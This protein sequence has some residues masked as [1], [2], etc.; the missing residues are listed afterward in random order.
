MK[1]LRTNWKMGMLL[2]DT[3]VCIDCE[4]TGL[5]TETD[6]IIE[7]AIVKFNLDGV[8]DSY[9][10]L[11]DPKRDIPEESTV[12]HHI[13]DDMVQG[14]PTIDQVL[15]KV[16]AIA[17][18]HTI[19]GHGIQFDI[20][21][22]VNAAK[23]NDIPCTLQNRPSLDTLRLARLYG[24]A[25][26][27]SL[28]MLR[29]HFNIPEQGAHRA[30]NDVMVNID[31]F[32][33]LVRD[34][35]T[36]DQVHKALSKP[37]RLKNMPLGKH[38]GRP[39]KEVPVEYLRWAANKDFDQDLLFSIRSELKRRKTSKQADFAREANPFSDL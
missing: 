26:T 2:K 24:Q 30:M 1:P 16:L 14:Q 23:R 20:D 28:E 3:F 12:I 18:R 4:S 7:V 31:V 29:K 22:I 32:K 5:E 37:I 6:S 25:P 17:G 13:T 38:K 15:G 34:F 35:K 33:H 11:V 19:V 8:V 9:E 21:L 10:T 36:T 27:N 39:F